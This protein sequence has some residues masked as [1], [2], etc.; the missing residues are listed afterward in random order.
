[1]GDQM[2]SRPEGEHGNQGEAAISSD[3]ESGPSATISR[4]ELLR[5][6]GTAGAG[7][8]LTAVLPGI[9]WA[10]AADYW[11][12][13]V[14]WPTGWTSPLKKSPIN[15]TCRY[16]AFSGGCNNEDRSHYWSYYMESG[17]GEHLGVDIQAP[18]GTPVYAVAD[19]LVRKVGTSW[20]AQWAQ[21]AVISHRTKQGGWFSSAYGHLAIGKNPRTNKTWTTNDMI[22]AGE[23]IGTTTTM[24]AAPAHLHFGLIPKSITSIPGMSSS[25]SKSCTHHPAGTVDPLAFLSGKTRVGLAG[26][27]VKWK[28]S[29]GSYT[30]WEVYSKSGSL[31]RRWVPDVATYNCLVNGGAVN[32]GPMSSRFLDQLPDQAGV[33]ASC[34]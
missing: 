2:I 27:I 20:G 9:A 28:N 30:S 4:R 34:R 21:V 24:S 6:L 5:V 8:G 7:L 23:K 3:S 16:G 13:S 26:S 29:D 14:N 12:K 31:A 11:A 1:M 33:W 17:L 22:R 19:G 32:W 25:A 18:N 10:H 15:M